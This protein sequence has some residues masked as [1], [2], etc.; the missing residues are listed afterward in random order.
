MCE[1]GRDFLETAWNAETQTPC[2]NLASWADLSRGLYFLQSGAFGLISATIRVSKVKPP[3]L[4]EM[5][6]G[7]SQTHTH[8]GRDFTP[9]S[10]EEIASATE[11]FFGPP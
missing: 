4:E 1:F 9:V 10:T 11:H 6:P 5:S 2:R 7:Q 8:I 3:A